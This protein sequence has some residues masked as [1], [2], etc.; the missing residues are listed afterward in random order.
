M[1]NVKVQGQAEASEAGCSASPGTQCWAS[2]SRL[3]VAQQHERHSLLTAFIAPEPHR[4]CLPHIPNG[5]NK[6]DNV[7]FTVL[8]RACQLVA[9]ATGLSDVYQVLH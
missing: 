2:L 5:L 6:Q 8:I 3:F 9:F 7:C 4:P 1:P